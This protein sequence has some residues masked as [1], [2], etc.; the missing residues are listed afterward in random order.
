MVDRILA[1]YSEMMHDDELDELHALLRRFA[2][3]IARDE[4]R[5]MRLA[6]QNSRAA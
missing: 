2:M 1:S 4:A 6:L 5:D 3:Q